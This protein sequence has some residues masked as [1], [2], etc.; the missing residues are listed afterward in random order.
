MPGGSDDYDYSKSTTRR[1]AWCGHVD[2]A[3]SLELAAACR[4]ATF[5]AKPE[6]LC[7]MGE[8][9]YKAAMA[10]F[11]RFQFVPRA[12]VFRGPLN[13]RDRAGLDGDVGM[14]MVVS[15]ADINVMSF[16]EEGAMYQYHPPRVAMRNALLEVGAYTVTEPTGAI[17]YDRGELVPPWRAWRRGI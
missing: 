1:G 5:L 2:C 13:D 7:E 16:F 3:E 14:L 17:V 15:Y 10:V 12:R 8:A 6:G 9:A 4:Q 11:N